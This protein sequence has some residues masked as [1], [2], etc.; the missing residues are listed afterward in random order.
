MA[1]RSLPPTTPALRP[2][3]VILLSENLELLVTVKFCP[4][5]KSKQTA[6][7]NRE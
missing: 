7:V 2:E 4:P 3:L 1:G 6:G 5:F